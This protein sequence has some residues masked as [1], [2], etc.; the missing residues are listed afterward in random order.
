MQ[1]LRTLPSDEAE[2]VT[3]VVQSG[4]SLREAT[5]HGHVSAMIIQRRMKRGLKRLS[6]QLK[7]A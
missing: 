5:K 1:A 2:A 4:Q 7:Q 6:R 3:A